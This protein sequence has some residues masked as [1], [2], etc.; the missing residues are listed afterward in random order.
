MPE[1]G[2]IA[3]SRKKAASSLSVAWPNT[4]GSL[5]SELRV[6]VEEEAT[7]ELCRQRYSLQCI[8]SIPLLTTALS[9][10]MPS[11]EVELIIRIVESTTRSEF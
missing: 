7:P 9:I 2:E 3:N 11:F 8:K 6:Y 4:T 1:W 5:K 10:V